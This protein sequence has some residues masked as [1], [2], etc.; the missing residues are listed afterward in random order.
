MA[1]IYTHELMRELDLYEPKSCFAFGL[2]K[3]E[4]K[5]KEKKTPIFFLYA[6]GAT[7]Y[8]LYSLIL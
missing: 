8:K 2:S 1:K 5:K 4:K 3:I 6:L 7:N